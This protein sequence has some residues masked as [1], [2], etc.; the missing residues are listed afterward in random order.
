MALRYALMLP[1]QELITSG[2]VFCARHIPRK[3]PSLLL[4]HSK[5]PRLPGPINLLGFV[6]KRSDVS[7]GM[8]A[9]GAQSKVLRARLAAG[10]DSV[11]GGQRDVRRVA[12]AARLI[13]QV[14]GE[15]GGV[16][17]AGRKN[18]H[19]SAWAMSHTP[20]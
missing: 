8:Q 1:S 13:H 16:I 2:H 4:E 3:P 19:I 10:Q 6:T 5:W 11:V 18:P 14:D 20:G 15:D 12:L 9:M 7:K 17:P